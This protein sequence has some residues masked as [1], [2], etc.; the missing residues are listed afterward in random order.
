MSD[1]QPSDTHPTRVSKVGAVLLSAA[2]VFVI[3]LILAAFQIA[4]VMSM[5]LA[6]MLL[7]LAWLIAVIAL[8][9]WLSSRTQKHSGKIVPL[10]AF[11]LGAVFLVTDFV[12][13]RLKAEQEHHPPPSLREWLSPATTYVLNLPLG[14]IAL[15]LVIGFLLAVWLLRNLRRSEPDPN[16]QGQ[17][18]RIEELER[19][20]SALEKARQHAS[21]LYEKARKENDALQ[22]SLTNKI[23]YLE[24]QKWLHD[25]A[26]RDKREIDKYV[27]AK[28]PS[29]HY[30]GLRADLPYIVI[31]FRVFNYSIHPISIDP[32]D[33]KGSIY[34]NEQEL[35][36]NLKMEGDVINLSR[37]GSHW[38]L[39]I[40][41]WIDPIE[42][43]LLV[44]PLRDIQLKFDKLKIIIKGGDGTSGIEP[45]RLRL[46]SAIPV[47][48]TWPPN[49]RVNELKTRIEGVCCEH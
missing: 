3:G 40:K 31:T 39:A 34:R 26:E 33:V 25:L 8:W 36:G 6:H 18:S 43:E 45:R 23:H 21:N 1:Q 27:V 28:D 13:V 41:Q 5:G 47:A 29:V 24:S 12:M 4:G 16:V 14:W 10:A 19:E 46:P 37:D 38:E 48:E 35:S 20:N 30:G 15:S 49:I 7:A 32:K 42:A 2:S 44:N 22:M 9:G 11:M 17:E